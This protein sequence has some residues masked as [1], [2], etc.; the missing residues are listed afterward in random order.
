MRERH[1]ESAR[2]HSGDLGERVGQWAPADLDAVDGDRTVEVAVGNT[3]SGSSGTGDHHP[4]GLD[5]HPV[6]VGRLGDHHPRR[7]HGEHPCDPTRQQLDAGTRT[8]TDRHDS[9]RRARIEEVDRFAL[10]VQ[11]APGHH[12]G[13]DACARPIEQR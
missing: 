13:R 10:G 7:I 9:I 2:R 3:K 11:V 12:P 4:S 1:E 6:P 8:N 5:G